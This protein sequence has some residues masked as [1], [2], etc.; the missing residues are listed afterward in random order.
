MLQ[1]IRDRAQSWIAFLIVGLLILGLASVAWEAYFGPDPEVSV[2]RVNGEKITVND[3]QR[4]YQQQRARLQQMLGGAD[5]SQF[6]PDETEFKKDILE[7]LENEEMILQE[8]GRAGFRVSDRLLAEQIRSFEAFQIDGEFSSASYESWLGQNF[9]SPGG[10]E[11][12]LREDGM[13]QQY[14]AGIADT[15]WATDSELKAIQLRQEQKRDVGYVLISKDS[16]LADINVSD[17]DANSY[18]DKFPQKFETEEK[19]SA[20][21]LELSLD[22]LSSDV[23]VD[24]EI[25]KESYEER[26]SEFGLPEERRTRHILIEA[27]GDSSD[28]EIAAAKAKAEELLE[29]IRAGESFEELAKESSDDF[30]SANDG[31]DLGFLT[32]DTMM[33]ETFADAAFAL[34]VGDVSEPVMSNYGFHII[35]LDEVKAEKR[36]SY[37]EVREELANDYRQRQAE[38]T[39]F[40][41]GEI[42]ANL[43]FENPDSLE[44]AAEELGLTVKTTPMMTRNSGVGIAANPEVR[45]LIFS[46]EVLGQGLNSEPFEL[47]TTQLIVVR[48]KEHQEIALRPFDD[49]KDEIIDMIKVERAEAAA[50]KEGEAVIASVSDDIQLEAMAEE[51][52]FEWNHVGEIKR[53]DMAV[54]RDVL[55]EAFAMSRPEEGKKV[56]S[57]VK[58][59]SGDY[60][61]VALLNVIDGELTDDTAK[62]ETA[63]TSRERYYGVSELTGAINSLRNAAEVIE[64]PENL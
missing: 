32:R 9:L 39:F 36:K 31:G 18:Y 24:E 47:S 6:I 23:D 20:E 41:Q 48:V 11:D 28:E 13:L 38:D 7:R 55:T 3:F 21:Y 8:A 59:A 19:V 17:D 2:A 15:A 60:A 50:K 43:V 56:Y 42:L 4:A 62:L 58:L 35:K 61:V 27:A 33:D 29:K 1:F 52:G 51:K 14:R 26:L 40:E 44:I 16:Y 34:N 45:D 64:Y 22:V 12:M 53:N 57:N 25:L 63:R 46:D 49:V 54:D 5:I 30:G 10:F 37:E